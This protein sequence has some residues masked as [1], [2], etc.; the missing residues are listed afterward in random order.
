MPTSHSVSKVLLIADHRSPAT[1]VTPAPVRRFRI[2]RLRLDGRS[3]L[4]AARYD[5]LKRVFD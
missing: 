2:A 4:P 3:T 5:H 1:R